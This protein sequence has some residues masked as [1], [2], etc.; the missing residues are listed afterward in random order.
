MVNKIQMYR[1][2]FLIIKDCK[3]ST[4]KNR[5]LG[6]LITEMEN[7]FNIPGMKDEEFNKANPVVMALYTDISNE[8]VF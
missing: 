7:E 6:R 5:Q 1:D 3:D 4:F 8:R 2:Q